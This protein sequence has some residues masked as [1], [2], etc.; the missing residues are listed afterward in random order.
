MIYHTN[1]RYIDSLHY[2]CVYAP[3]EYCYTQTI[4][5]THHIYMEAFFYVSGYELRVL[6]CQKD[7]LHTSQVYCRPSVCAR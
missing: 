1:Y 2:V 5:C 6:S 3:S 4:Y 7:F